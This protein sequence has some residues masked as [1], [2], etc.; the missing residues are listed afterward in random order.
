MLEK[1]GAST[2]SVADNEALQAG[3]ANASIQLAIAPEPYITRAKF[4]NNDIELGPDVAQLWSEVDGCDIVSSVLVARKDFVENNKDSMIYILD[5]FKQSVNTV[6]YGVSKTLE[7]SSK[8]NIVPDKS[9]AIS[10][11]KNC[12]F[13]FSEGSDMQQAVEAFLNANSD[14]VSSMPGSDFYYIQ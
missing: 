6:I 7:Y 14:A 5:D 13:T 2:A 8:F 9:E 4:Q 12:N 10:S 11:M 3:L 1:S